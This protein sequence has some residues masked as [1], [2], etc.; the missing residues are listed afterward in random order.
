M[1]IYTEV[2]ETYEKNK[3]TLLYNLDVKA[4]MKRF[5]DHFQTNALFYLIKHV[6]DEL[7]TSNDC[8]LIIK[9]VCSTYNINAF[10][11][12]VDTVLVGRMCLLTRKAEYHITV[13]Q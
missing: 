3:I 6:V 5:C 1:A 13:G 4:E 2:L 7:S 10:I 9:C 12:N 8:A 11:T